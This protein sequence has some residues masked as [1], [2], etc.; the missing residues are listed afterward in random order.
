MKK[1]KNKNI[2]RNTIV[3]FIDLESN[4]VGYVAFIGYDRFVAIKVE[5]TAT[6]PNIAYSAT[7]SKHSVQEV[8]T[9]LKSRWGES[10][11]I[12][13]EFKSL[14]KLYKWLAK[15]SHHRY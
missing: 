15:G 11:F 2:T 7:S 14:K 5:R 6:V 8:V 9:Q 4:R 3:G 1:L 12:F 13:Y 10:N